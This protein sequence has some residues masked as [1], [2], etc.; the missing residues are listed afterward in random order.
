MDNKAGN[1]NSIRLANP[2]HVGVF[3]KSEILAHYPLTVAETAERLGIAKFNFES[4]LAGEGTLS[5]DLAVR[6]QGLFGVR[7]KTL[8]E[9]QESFEVAKL[10]RDG[11]KQ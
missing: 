4:F 1:N 3:I 8:L 5:N 6:L 7:A 9:M 2:P 10:P 11:L